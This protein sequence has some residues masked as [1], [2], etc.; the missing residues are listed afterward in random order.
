MSS[1]FFKENEEKKTRKIFVGKAYLSTYFEK[2]L[3]L[4]KIIIKN[5]NFGLSDLNI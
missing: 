4:W 3:K 5:I 1:I 2:N